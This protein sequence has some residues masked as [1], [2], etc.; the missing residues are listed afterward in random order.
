MLALNRADSV[1]LIAALALLAFLYLRFWGDATQGEQA[2]IL[3]GGSE[4]SV[5]SLY[6]DQ[7]LHIPGT[8]GI[9]ELEIRA[10]KIRFVDAPCQGKQCIHTGWLALGGEVAACL[11]NR[12]TVQV[13]GREPRFD[14]INF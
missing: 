5:V 7:R 12:I 9:S 14:A 6:K 13:I 11:P 10:G 2:R 3:V 8:L 4:F 1:I